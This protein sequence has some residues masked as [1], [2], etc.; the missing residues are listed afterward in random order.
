VQILCDAAVARQCR[1]LVPHLPDVDR[2]C[3]FAAADYGEAWLGEQADCDTLLILPYARLRAYWPPLFAG[4][5]CI[6]P[7]PFTDPAA[8]ERWVAAFSAQAEAPSRA[9]VSCMQ[10]PFYDQ[11]ARRIATRL[12]NIARFEEVL[13]K[14]PCDTDRAELAA[15]LADGYRL[16]FYCGHGRS[17]GFSGYRGIRWEHLAAPPLRRP[18]GAFISLTC[19]TLAADK[20]HSNPIGIDW[21]NSGRLVSYV[22]FADAVRIAPLARITHLLLRE[23]GD[24]ATL[25][26]WLR[27]VRAAVPADDAEA[28]E[29][30]AA[31]RLVG[32]AEVRLTPG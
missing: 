23:L 28:L 30:F 13:L 27:R 25:K 24:A 14:R 15:V 12:G 2:F 31:L 26:A 1:A 29:T 10:K 21:I 32:S 9:V 7:L 16:A 17:R 6:Q 22:G 8:C 20:Q 19:S 5:R 18:G 4:D 11:W 3:A